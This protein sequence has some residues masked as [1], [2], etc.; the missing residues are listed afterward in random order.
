M[1]VCVC[2]CVYMSRVGV[3]RGVGEREGG[4]SQG[5]RGEARE[6]FGFCIVLSLFGP[7][8]LSCLHGE[9]SS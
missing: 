5:R 3:L 9:K 4:F 6:G 2:V 7:R 8:D 1:C